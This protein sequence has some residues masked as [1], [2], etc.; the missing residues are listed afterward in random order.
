MAY[1][2]YAAELKDKDNNVYGIMD[3]ENREEVSNLKSAISPIVLFSGTTKNNDVILTKDD[4]YEAKT[5]Y[6][7]FDVVTSVA[8]YIE[9]MDS[10]NQRI[11]YIGKGSSSSGALHYEGQIAVPSN[12]S[13]AKVTISTT[14]ARM[15]I[16]GFGIYPSTEYYTQSL[17]AITESNEL[18]PIVLY[19]G[20]PLAGINLSQKMILLAQKLYF[21]NLM[22]QVDMLHIL[23][24][25]IPTIRG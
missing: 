10:N 13:Y 16:N 15:T 2:R 14:D 21:I 20:S 18:Q 8:S 4:I 19:S 9:F 25:W 12:F 23:N 5:F 22:L 11:S 3:A 24:L 7:D 17:K 1:N 6:Y